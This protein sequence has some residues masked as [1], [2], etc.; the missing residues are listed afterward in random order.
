MNSGA[1][2]C[3]TENLTRLSLLLFAAALA[4]IAAPAESE[5]V[6]AARANRTADTSRLIRG[7]ADLD[8]ADSRGYTPLM[9]AASWG[10]RETVGQ[11]MAGGARINRVASGGATALS[12][13]VQNG[14]GPVA[15]ALLKAGANFYGTS[16]RA[17]E[18]GQQLL[19]AAGAGNTSEIESLLRAGAS[20]GFVPSHPPR[21]TAM[22]ICARRGDLACIHALQAAGAIVSADHVD[23]LS[24]LDSAMRAGKPE[25]ARLLRSL[26]AVSARAEPTPPETTVRLQAALRRIVTA[27]HRLNAA[28]GLRSRVALAS[29]WLLV[30]SAGNPD[31]SPDYIA[32][33][34]R[35]ADVLESRSRQPELLED[36]AKDLELKT[37]HCRQLGIGMGGRIRLL[38]NTRR[39]GQ[40]VNNWQ[41]FY[42]PKIFQNAPGVSPESHSR[43]EQPRARIDRAGALY[44]LGARSGFEQ[45]Q[46]PGDRS[47]QR[48]RR[49]HARSGGGMRSS[50]IHGAVALGAVLAALVWPLSAALPAGDAGVARASAAVASLII[51]TGMAFGRRAIPGGRRLWNVAAGAATCAALALV[52]VQYDADSSC[53]ATY[54]SRPK[55]IGRVLQPYVNPE[56]GASP[57]SLLFDAAGVAERVWKPSSIR[58]CRWLLG[59]VGM[60]A[61]PLFAFSACCLAGSARP[62]ALPARRPPAP[63]QA[64]AFDAFISYRH[65]EPDRG[66]AFELLDKLET[67]GLRAA[68]DARDFRPNEH[69]LSEMER[70]IQSSRYVL[71]VV[72]PRYVASDHCVEEAVLSKTL[73][74]SERTRRIVPLIFERVELPVWLHGIVGIDFSGAGAVDPFERLRALLLPLAGR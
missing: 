66:Y 30:R 37:A 1:N 49:D 3:F 70:C 67:W 34:E 22:I 35:A 26:G 7:G 40:A 51:C 61:I 46:P 21:E 9:W 19:A 68:I 15:A 55:I 39:T 25:A 47:A 14:H 58:T 52:F 33:L 28:G 65:T 64:D 48:A 50:A 24:P 10:D 42:L 57:S 69:F 12:L 45:G 60:A 71:C 72:T 2:I 5:L 41:V 8:A 54:E 29:E 4:S 32:E 27:G 13:A 56:P 63:R 62:S 17:V 73:D 53:V 74:M 16:G 44:R 31:V 18:I 20:T 23:G 38:V 36:V 11:L 59:W 6:I 43:V